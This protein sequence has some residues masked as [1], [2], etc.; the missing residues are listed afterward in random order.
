MISEVTAPLV[1]AAQIASAEEVTVD[2]RALLL[3]VST[4]PS[5]I[6]NATLSRAGK[7]RT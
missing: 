1:D 3:T 7:P 2:W 4:G 6:L 5:T